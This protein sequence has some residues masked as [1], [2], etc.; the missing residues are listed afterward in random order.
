MLI[1]SLLLLCSSDSIYLNWLVIFQALYTTLLPLKMVYI[2]PLMSPLWVNHIT[3]SMAITNKWD[4]IIH[5]CITPDF[6]EKAISDN[7][8]LQNCSCPENVLLTN[9][10]VN[11]IFFPDRYSSAA[12]NWP[13][14]HLKFEQ[15]ALTISLS[16][17]V[18]HCVAGSSVSF[19]FYQNQ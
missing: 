7:C 18:F 16:L 2:M 5:P 19:F 11:K 3:Q 15:K 9:Q 12:N 14:V 6:K 17:L 8:Q 4:D 1:Y 13:T 10:S